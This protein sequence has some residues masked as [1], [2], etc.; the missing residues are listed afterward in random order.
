MNKTIKKLRNKIWLTLSISFSSLVILMLAIIY[1]LMS[2]NTQHMIYQSLNMRL[3]SEAYFFEDIFFSVFISSEETRN[4]HASSQYL[5]TSTLESLVSQALPLID[6]H[7]YHHLLMDDATWAYMVQGAYTIES[8]THTTDYTQIIFVNVTELMDKLKRLLLILSVIGSASLFV[9]IIG[10]FFVANKLVKPTIR[11][12]AKEKEVNA[13]QKRFIANASHELRT[14]LTL[15]KGSYDEVLD[16]LSKT[17]ISQKKWFNVMDFGIRRMESLTEEL[18][19][20]SELAHHKSGKIDKNDVVDLCGLVQ[21]VVAVLEMKVV[22]KGITISTSENLG[23]MVKQNREKLKQVVLILLDNAIKYVNPK[24]WIK[25]EVLSVDKQVNLCV[26][27]SGKG[28]STVDLPHIFERFYR[29]N[30][31]SGKS[32]GHGLGLAIAKETIE[33][34]GGEIFAESV[35]GETTTFGFTLFIE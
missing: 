20:L 32:K 31:V 3:S 34:L 21:E 17:V 15:V 27:N 33:L 7:Y 10:N 22:E 14:P 30:D 35:V 24:G 29:G 13:F 19:L 26:K 23:I 5:S 9:I 11:A 6:D 12:F 25:V 16:N 1:L 28:I 18:L 2:Q 4:I 8:E